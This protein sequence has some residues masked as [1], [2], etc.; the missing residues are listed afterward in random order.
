MW[1]ENFNVN[2]CRNYRAGFRV[3]SVSLAASGAFRL[4]LLFN[5]G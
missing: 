2:V 5:L 4:I 1:G 3:A